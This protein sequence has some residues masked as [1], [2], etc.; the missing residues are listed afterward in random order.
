MPVLQGRRFAS[1]IWWKESLC[2]PASCCWW[3]QVELHAPH[4]LHALSSASCAHPVGLSPRT[5]VFGGDH[6]LGFSC[7]CHGPAGLLGNWYLEE[8]P[9]QPCVAPR[10]LLNSSRCLNQMMHA[11]TANWC[12]ISKHGATTKPKPKKTNHDN[13]M[14]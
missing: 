11:Q 2:L 1:L 4:P 3:G 12:V 7:I 6:L 14:T 5:R 13:K 8:D 9:W 10:P